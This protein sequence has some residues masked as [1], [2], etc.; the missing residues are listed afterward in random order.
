M[1]S[2][3]NPSDAILA[4]KTARE[5][6]ALPKISEANGL[7]HHEIVQRLPGFVRDKSD[8]GRVID[9]AEKRSLVR[10]QIEWVDQVTESSYDPH[11]S[12]IRNL[13]VFPALVRADQPPHRQKIRPIF[14]E[15]LPGTRC[16]LSPGLSTN[17]PKTAETAHKQFSSA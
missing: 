10:N 16:P 12:I 9:E 17:R 6:R 15:R 4:R 11:Q 3:I 7:P 13:L 2:L 8:N 1:I 5:T 14:L